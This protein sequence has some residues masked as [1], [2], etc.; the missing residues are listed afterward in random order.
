[1]KWHASGTYVLFSLG[2]CVFNFF[3]IFLCMFLSSTSHT[4][5]RTD[6]NFIQNL[7]S[8]E[9]SDGEVLELTVRM[10]AHVSAHY[11]IY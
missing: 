9:L 1:M 11:S 4:Y 3:F 2:L 5:H 10:R 6:L 8:S 7:F